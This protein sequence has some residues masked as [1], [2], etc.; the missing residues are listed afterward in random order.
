MGVNFG[1]FSFACLFP[2]QDYIYYMYFVTVFPLVATALWYGIFLLVIT[3][4]RPR[5]SI[6]S[7]IQSRFLYAFM[8]FT[9]FILPGISTMIAR[10]F[11][12]ENLDPDLATG[13]TQYFLR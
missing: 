11:A 6:Y 5:P 10:S 12:C 13:S 1:T 9:N 8:L 3:L 2:E 7:R 4:F